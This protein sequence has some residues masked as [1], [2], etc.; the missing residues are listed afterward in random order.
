[1]RQPSYHPRLKPLC[2]SLLSVLPALAFGADPAAPDPAGAPPMAIVEVTGT[3]QSRQV[4]NITRADLKTM[5][6]YNTYKVAGLPP[7]YAALSIVETANTNFRMFM[8]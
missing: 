5:H 7:A 4:Q 2:L 8:V 6:P 1:M 3:G